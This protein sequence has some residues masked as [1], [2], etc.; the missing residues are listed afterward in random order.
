M[1]E[2]SLI[3]Q[4]LK[5]FDPGLMVHV[6][7]TSFVF[8]YKDGGF[9]MLFWSGHQRAGTTQQSSISIWKYTAP[10]LVTKVDWK[11]IVE[12]IVPLISQQKLSAISSRLNSEYLCFRGLYSTVYISLQRLDLW[13]PNISYIVQSKKY[14]AFHQT[15]TRS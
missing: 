15:Q 9:R 3:S 4:D 13:F 5:R 10:S 1:F 2:P 11:W 6:Q 12:W 14:L 8:L 7:T